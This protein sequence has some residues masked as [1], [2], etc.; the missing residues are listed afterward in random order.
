MSRFRETLIIAGAAAA[1]PNSAT[2]RAIACRDVDRLG[3]GWTGDLPNAK[4]QLAEAIISTIH[5]LAAAPTPE[6][7]LPIATALR[8]LVAAGRV[9]MPRSLAPMRHEP[10]RWWLEEDR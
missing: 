7:R 10:R 2:H 8:D 6:H 9:P 4:A 1:N 3:R 5:A